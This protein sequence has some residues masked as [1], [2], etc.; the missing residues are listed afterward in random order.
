MAKLVLDICY[1]CAGHTKEE[2]LK[3]VKGLA[4]GCSITICD[5]CDRQIGNTTGVYH[6]TYPLASNYKIAVKI[7]SFGITEIEMTQK[8]IHDYE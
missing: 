2:H 7:G 5:I 8:T 3:R 6:K 4:G 1:E